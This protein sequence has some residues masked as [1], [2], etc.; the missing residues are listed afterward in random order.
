MVQPVIQ[1]NFD[2]TFQMFHLTMLFLLLK[3]DGISALSHERVSYIGLRKAGDH[4]SGSSYPLHSQSMVKRSTAD[5]VYFEDP[6]IFDASPQ[7]KTF[8]IHKSE[9][10]SRD[11]ILEVSNPV[12]HDLM[13]VGARH[14]KEIEKSVTCCALDSRLLR[15]SNPPQNNRHSNSNSS[16]STPTDIFPV[17][18]V[19]EGSG[20]HPLEPDTEDTNPGSQRITSME[21]EG[22]SKTSGSMVTPSN[23]NRQ[24]Y[25]ITSYTSNSHLDHSYIPTKSENVLQRGL[26]S[27]D[28]VSTSSRKMNESNNNSE[29]VSDTP[30][31]TS[32]QW[33]HWPFQRTLITEPNTIQSSNDSWSVCKPGYIH[34]NDSCWSVC[35]LIPNYCYN[36]GECGVIENVGAICRCSAKDHTWYR[37]RRC[38]TVITEVQLTCILI[39]ASLL[40]AI[41]FLILIVT[42]TLKLRSLKKAQQRF[43]SRRKLWISSGLQGNSSFTSEISQQGNHSPLAR[44]SPDTQCTPVSEK[45]LTQFIDFELST[46]G[47][48]R[49]C[50]TCIGNSWRSPELSQDTS[51]RR[52]LLRSPPAVAPPAGGAV[53]QADYNSCILWRTERTAV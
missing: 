41:L 13:G 53:S 6:L 29:G 32:E 49:E 24:K 38:Q 34:K 10:E 37:G 4:S 50:K 45:H 20:L 46:L 40:V 44:C 7:F 23:E 33:E 15:N 52:Q 14:Y 42:F 12:P 36:G 16:V 22:T 25:L 18:E 28:G 17:N 31:A 5:H 35:E 43:D 47:N 2:R 51:D 39:G 48:M 19:I 8:V 1:Y 11:A 9:S 30:T 27:L 26:P 21:F 3:G